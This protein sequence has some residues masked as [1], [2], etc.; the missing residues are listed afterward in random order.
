M[1]GKSPTGGMTPTS[2]VVAPV[3]SFNCSG[4][5]GMLVFPLKG[6]DPGRKRCFRKGASEV[7]RI[8]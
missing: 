7:V 8:V 4:A 1:S 2:T 3:H 6:D 5:T